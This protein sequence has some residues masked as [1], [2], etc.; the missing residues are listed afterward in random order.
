MA[1]HTW[2]DRFVAINLHY[3]FERHGWARANF[4]LDPVDWAIIPVLDKKS[5]WRVTYGEDAD[6]PE[7][8]VAE[9]A[10]ARL[11]RLLPDAGPYE[12]ERIAPYRVHQRAVDRMRIGRVLLAGDAAHITNPCGGLGLTSG[13][14]DA[15]HLGEALAAVI[16]LRAPDSA[17][18]DYAHERLSIFR[19]V[20]SPAASENKRRLSE[21]DPTRRQADVER[22]RRLDGDAVLQREALLFPNRLQSAPREFASA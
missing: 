20:A 19:D 2:P 17:L 6:L 15:M 1:G 12:I 3:D 14:L 22:L 9:R 7:E 5:G 16:Q 18:D 4:L 10:G 8:T 21:A 11:A 13:I